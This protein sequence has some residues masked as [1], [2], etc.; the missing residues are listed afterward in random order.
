MLWL[1]AG[2]VPGFMITGFWTA[3]FGS[4]LLSIVTWFLNQI[5]D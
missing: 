4:I 1:A 5:L 2:I 3:L